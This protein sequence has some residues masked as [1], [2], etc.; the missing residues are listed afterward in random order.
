[1]RYNND[2]YDNNYL[3]III[4]KNKLPLCLILKFDLMS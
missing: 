1:M 3:V 2:Y 4:I